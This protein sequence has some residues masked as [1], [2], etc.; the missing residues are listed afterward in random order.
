MSI[1]QDYNLKELC[2]RKLPLQKINTDGHDVSTNC[3]M[4]VWRYKKYIHK[5]VKYKYK[6]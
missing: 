4:S 1:P 2:K 6:V 3:N 5:Y